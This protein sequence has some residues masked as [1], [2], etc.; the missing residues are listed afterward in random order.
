[1]LRLYT[2]YPTPES[3]VNY[4]PVL[5]YRSIAKNL[6]DAGILTDFTNETDSV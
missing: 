4:L 3:V 5:P 2:C 1:M 6:L